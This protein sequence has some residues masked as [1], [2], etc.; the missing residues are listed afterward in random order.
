MIVCVRTPKGR[1]KED[2]YYMSHALRLSLSAIEQDLYLAPKPPKIGAQC[3][4]RSHMMWIEVRL[5]ML[6]FF[7]AF[8][9]WGISFS[10]WKEVNVVC[11]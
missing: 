4:Q 8:D 6:I 7:Y 3:A 5:A 2:D 1:Y 10:L 9:P 11:V